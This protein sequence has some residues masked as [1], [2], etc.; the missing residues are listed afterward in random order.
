MGF[1][2]GCFGRQGRRLLAFKLEAKG[3]V[4][5]CYCNWKP[6][7]SG[8]PQGSV[9]GPLLF[10]TYINDLDVNVEGLSRKLADD[11]K[12]GSVGSNEED[13]LGL[14]PDIDQL[15]NWAEQWQ[16]EL[17]PDKC[18]RRLRGDLI[19]VFKVL[20]GID[21]VDHDTLFPIAD[22]SKTGRHK[23]KKEPMWVQQGTWRYWHHIE[24]GP[25]AK[26]WR[27]NS[28]NF[29]FVGFSAGDNEA[30]AEGHQCR[31]QH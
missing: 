13:G 8:V 2:L 16:I 3:D 27:L 15:V 9:L 7:T 22:V 25:A 10:V 1:L 23:F 19:E 5:G 4:E 31:W 17:N 29:D 18:E 21:R 24:V 12:T 30:L 6:V 28:G 11:M 14:Q 26:S 20:R